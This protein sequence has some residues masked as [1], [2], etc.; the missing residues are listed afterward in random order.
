MISLVVPMLNEQENVGSVYLRVSD[1]A[2]SWGDEYEVI[3]VDDG[4]TDGTSEA[5]TKVCIEDS[6]WKVLSFSRNFGHQA[7]VSAGIRHSSGN[8]VAVM[9]GDLQDPPEVINELLEQW[10][11]G[12]HVA[13]AVRRARKEH[14][15]KR[16]AYA[17][18]YRTLKRIAVIEMPLDSGDF[19]VMDRAVV[20]VLNA[21][22]ERE[23]FVRGLRSWV[24]FRQT[25]VEYER[26]A[27][28][29]GRPQYT[30][31][32]LC[33]LAASGLISFSSVPLRLASWLGFGL[34]GCSALMTVLLIVW[35]ISGVRIAGVN[36]SDTV[37]WT[38]MICMV[39][40]LTGVQLLMT[41]IVGEYIARIFD[42][43]KGR[44]AWVVARAINFSNG[45]DCRS[46]G[47]QFTAS[48]YTA[49][50]RFGVNQSREI[51]ESGNDGRL[52]VE[53]HAGAGRQEVVS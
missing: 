34:C 24:G 5:L 40:F 10:R 43:V 26:S 21:L 17:A 31:T 49:D 36:P 47:E 33:R 39:Q 28:A 38:S 48:M 14:F 20:D 19:C 23:R 50:R 37:G 35:W 46:P 12:F 11:Q 2:L 42:E 22:P 18:F 52:N 13:Y 1:A 9:D 6:R 32:K 4:S 30:F 53:Q 25:G 29:A 27:R 45:A 7:A 16:I 41:G 3:V 44:P 51:S 8:V 15:L